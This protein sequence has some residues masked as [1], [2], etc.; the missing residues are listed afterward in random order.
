MT[1]ELTEKEIEKLDYIQDSVF[2]SIGLP[3]FDFSVNIHSEKNK[4]GLRTA[5]SLFNR[6]I[7]G[8]TYRQIDPKF[9]KNFDFINCLVF[10]KKKINDTDLIF[11]LFYD[12][13]NEISRDYYLGHL[14]LYYLNK[15]EKV[16][17][18]KRYFNLFQEYFVFNY[19][20]YLSRVQGDYEF[21]TLIQIFKLDLTKYIKKKRDENTHVKVINKLCW[22]LDKIKNHPNFHLIEKALFEQTTKD[23]SLI[24][25]LF[26]LGNFYYLQN[27]KKKALNYFSIS[28]LSDDYFHEY[29]KSNLFYSILLEKKDF[30]KI[31]RYTYTNHV[32]YIGNQ[33]P[34]YLLYRIFS[35]HEKKSIESAYNQVETY[36]RAHYINK[37]FLKNTLQAPLLFGAIIFTHLIEKHKLTFLDFI[38]VTHKEFKLIEIFSVFLAHFNESYKDDPNFQLVKAKAFEVLGNYE[39]A[40]ECASQG[41]TLDPKNDLFFYM[42]LDYRSK[43]NG[44]T[45]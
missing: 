17:E 5:K 33:E 11:D 27:E 37:R 28:C 8:Y 6:S 7:G 35:Y 4:Q 3:I 10:S 19:L 23:P 45:L 38:P 26:L 30:D 21:E 25:V 14:F 2:N 31:I 39:A 22:V 44:C 20:N 32:S 42:M 24:S 13:I 12:L 41:N 36:V 29:E 43:I 18:N 15:F 1:L 9:A 40:F 34:Y 16:G